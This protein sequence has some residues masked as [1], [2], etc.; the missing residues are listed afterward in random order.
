MW[1]T[2]QLSDWPVIGRAATW[3]AGL[4][5]A[6][7]KRKWPLA[8]ITGKPYVSPRAQVACPDLVLG[9]ACF[10]D[11]HV[12]LFAGRDGGR[13]EL[14]PRAHL[15]RGTII[16]VGQGG[17]VTIGENTHVQAYCSLNGY[18]GSIRLG[19][20]VLLAP[21]CGLFA[22]QHRFEGRDRP[23]DQQ[24]LTTRGDIVIEDDVWLGAGAKVMDGVT[25]GQG[26][27]VGAGSVVL[28]DIPAFAV[29]AG[30]PARVIRLR[31]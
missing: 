19:R 1:L 20:H 5:L 22:Y 8:Q 10:I 29:A 11:D 17:A 15:N 21:G 13:I 28:D 7:Y 24:G 23:I 4:P 2:M 25:I 6:P 30:V 18:L 31:S 26:A 16:E 9:R 27:V 14:G 12:T 3:L